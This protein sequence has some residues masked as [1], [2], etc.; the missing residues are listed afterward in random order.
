ML[1]ISRDST[2]KNIFT[3][4]A[5]KHALLK[6]IYVLQGIRSEVVLLVIVTPFSFLFFFY[7]RD[8]APW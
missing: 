8:V 3:S 6:C 4:Q 2:F 1:Q 7:E 5:N